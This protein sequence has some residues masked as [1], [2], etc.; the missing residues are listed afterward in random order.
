MPAPVPPTRERE[1]EEVARVR[2]GML[3][4]IGSYELPDGTR[5]E[6]KSGDACEF[7]PSEPCPIGTTYRVHATKGNRS[8]ERVLKTKSMKILD[9][10]I[11]VVASGTT[12]RF[13]VTSV[14]R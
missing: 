5:L 13:R 10:T 6:I 14:T 12:T 8:E 4:D 3:L 9:H 1:P 7:D 2:F 11:E